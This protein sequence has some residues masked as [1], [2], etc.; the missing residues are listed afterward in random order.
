MNSATCSKHMVVPNLPHSRYKL[1]TYLPK[2]A[3]YQN[4]G[5]WV[6]RDVKINREGSLIVDARFSVLLEPQKKH[7]ATFLWEHLFIYF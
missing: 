3:S 4:I 7:S 6:V 5:L 2:V 1:Q